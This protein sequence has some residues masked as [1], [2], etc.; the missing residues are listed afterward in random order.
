MKSLVFAK[1]NF[2]ELIRDPLSLIFSIGLPVL[3]LALMSTIQKNIAVDIFK[4]ES[5]A[6]GM[7]IFSFS[8]ISLFSG[9][10]IS[11]DRM[12][13]FLTRL[14]TSPLK[15]FD[16]IVGYTIPLVM[17]SILQ[18]I[19]CFLTAI[20]FGLNINL[21][22]LYTILAL[23]PISLL[24]VS[25]GIIIGTLFTDKQSSGVASVL[26]QIVALF[27]GL[28]FDLSLVGGVVEKIAKSLPFFHSLEIVKDIMNGKVGAI[29][30]TNILFVSIYIVAT[31]VIAV[32]VFKRKMHSDKV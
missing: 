24:F 1:R 9:M 19:C 5:F 22:L 26:I 7:V 29:S 4:I 10:L 17:L 11:K 20:T 32:L 30:L 28:W 14:F 23:I 13:S 15:A 8:F 31:I 25:I 16:Y 12:S 18:C 6:P 2:K 3:L 27:S 21:N